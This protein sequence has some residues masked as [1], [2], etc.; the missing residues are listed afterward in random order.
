MAQ[1]TLPALEILL[2]PNTYY[3]LK[4]KWNEEKKTHEYVLSTPTNLWRVT[5]VLSDNLGEKLAMYWKQNENA[6]FLGMHNMD[7]I[8]EKLSTKEEPSAA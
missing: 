8:I 3:S 2:R 5:I 6:T 1:S 7:W 4:R